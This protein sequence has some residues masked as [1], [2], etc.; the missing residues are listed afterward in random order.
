MYH[1]QVLYLTKLKR[2]KFPSDLYIWDIGP[3][4]ELYLKQLF[5]MCEQLGIGKRDDYMHM[6]YGFVYLKGKGKMSSRAGNVVSAD[7]LMDEV[8]AKAKE[9]IKKSETSR[10]L[11]D[12]ESGAVAEAVGL[13]AIKYGFLK[14]SRTTDLQFDIDESLS[15]EGN[16]GPYIQYTYDRT[17]S[18]L[19]K[20][21]ISNLKSQNKLKIDKLVNTMETGKWKLEIN[22]EELSLLRTFVRFTDVISMSAKNYSPNLLCNFLYDL[23]SKFNLFYQKHDIL[24]QR[25]KNKEQSELRLILTSATGQIIKNGLNLLGIQSPEKM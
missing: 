4:Q 18:V 8:V 11:S 9:I 13:A 23:A 24:E 20:S 17:R 6:S 10:G 12:N 21:Q 5:A 7:E 19:R 2:E 14:L 1:T 3:E 16:S 25:T 15:L 22:S